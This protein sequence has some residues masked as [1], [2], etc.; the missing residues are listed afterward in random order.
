MVSSNER[1]QF[2][3]LVVGFDFVHPIL[4][5]LPLVTSF[6]AVVVV[7]VVVVPIHYPMTHSVVVVVV[8]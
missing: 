2:V 5:V 1:H 8:S 6:S 7:V 3:V 4:V